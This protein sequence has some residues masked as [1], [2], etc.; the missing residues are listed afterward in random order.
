MGTPVWQVQPSTPSSKNQIFFVSNCSPTPALIKVISLDSDSIWLVLTSCSS[1]ISPNK[2]LLLLVS[3]SICP[4][5]AP[6]AV[7]L[8]ICSAVIA[9]SLALDLTTSVSIR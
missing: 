9:A 8:A 2:S 6:S 5:I 4:A 7:V 3:V 1:V